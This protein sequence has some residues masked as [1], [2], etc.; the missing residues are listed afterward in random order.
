[1][2]AMLCMAGGMTMAQSNNTRITGVIHD[3]QGS[4]IPFAN[5]F[6]YAV[7]DSV[8]KKA[9][10]ADEEAKFSIE[11]AGYGNYYIK[12]TA[13]GYSDY[14]SPSFM[15]SSENPQ[16]ALDHIQLNDRALALSG[17]QVTARKPFI[18]QHLD[19]MVINVESSISASGSSALEILE[20]VPGVMIDRQS[21][22]IR[23]RNKSGV[24]IMID[25]RVAQ[26]TAEAL[27]QYL[28]NL[29]SAQI[30][31]I[32]IITNPS[33]RYD[34]AGNSG[35]INIRL[36]RN[37]N[38]GTN[39]IISINAGTGIL[40]RSHSDLHRGSFNINLNHK[41]EKWNLFSHM[42]ISRNS[43]FRDNYLLR[44]LA[45]SNGQ[46]EFDQYNKRYGSGINYSGR[47]GAEYQFNSKTSVGI[48]ADMNLWDGVNHSLGS[49]MMNEFKD[50]V[51]NFS[52]IYPKSE[53]DVTAD[54]YS[55][56][57]NFKHKHKNKEIA[58]DL[59]YG[60]FKNTSYQ[61]FTNHYYY[62]GGDSTNSQIAKQPNNT[63]ILSAKIDYS[64]AFKNELK[65]DL[66]AKANYHFADNNFTYDDYKEG[67]WI[68]NTIQTNHFQYKE[69]IQAGYLIGA[70][71]NKKWSFQAGFRGEYTIS[72]G[73]SLTLE[74]NTK[75]EYFKLFPTGYISYK[76]N[77]N[78]QLKYSFSKR[79][80]RP[81]YGSLNPFI[82]YLDPYFHVKGNPDLKPQYT[83]RNE[84]TYIFKDEYFT[85]VEYASTNGLISEVVMADGNIS[86]SQNQ[87]IARAENWALIFSIPS[88]FNSWWSIQNNF[89]AYRNKY[90]DNNLAG[91][92]L[93]NSSFSIGFVTTHNFTLPK[94][95]NIELNYWYNSPSAQGIYRQTKAQHAF[96]PSIQ[97]SIG[98]I[99]L[100]F[101]VT[102]VFLTSF[103]KGYSKNEKIVFNVS[104]RWNARRISLTISY[105]LGK[106]NFKS[107][108]QRNNTSGPEKFNGIGN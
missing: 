27:S 19:K 57:A 10:A 26:M 31:T 16:I 15:L 5:V 67:K 32:E 11:D 92:N 24:I 36:K 23:I 88:K 71:K 62:A 46:T 108:N 77:Q 20:K 34:A 97:K 65:L 45:N 104:N 60:L 17:V 101:N 37:K 44:N 28:N 33:S 84:L 55:T 95:W 69:S 39:G 51:T 56:N 81:N 100:R 72:E 22:Q 76:L 52:T 70:Y 2:V 64:I 47:L 59:D 68:R 103:Y 80:D 42:G 105:N 98:R 73:H 29:N 13:V 85:T 21:D 99:K 3:S 63:E 79:I 93:N 9:V 66:G 8:F 91:Q 89:T 6:L 25:G 78:H 41:T 86:I 18:E 7:A 49:S 83:N 87:N 40:P 106:Q 50:G 74:Q 107:Q 61:I 12:V 58:V 35:I 38:L 43:T 102:D 96:N 14:S 4:K 1:M 54:M 53:R 48:R 94:D 90:S 30:E 82:F 75:R